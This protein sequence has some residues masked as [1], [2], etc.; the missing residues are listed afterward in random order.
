MG[1]KTAKAMRGAW[2]TGG[3]RRAVGDV[4][5]CRA[6]M[7]TSFGPTL[8]VS[9][10]ASASLLASARGMPNNPMVATAPNQP[11]HFDARRHI[12]SASGILG[13]TA[14]RPGRRADPRR[15]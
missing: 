7:A 14:P 10:R 9:P 12:G 1:S 15:T 8:G 2:A 5:T 11:T 4:A 13:A 6:T 3:E